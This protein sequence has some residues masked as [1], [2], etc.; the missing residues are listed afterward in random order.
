M[1][2]S[3]GSIFRASAILLVPLM[4]L[5]PGCRPVPAG[6]VVK[7]LIE[8][9]FETEKYHVAE[10]RVGDIKPLSLGEKTYM[11]TPG[12]LVNISSITLE[13]RQ[14][15]GAQAAYRKGQHVTFTNARVSIKE[16][17]G[18]TGKWVITRIE[19]IPVP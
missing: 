8:R 5:L 3:P 17:P 18:H 13:I 7:A 14:D 19:G 9:H 2:A 11:G 4:F 16:Q 15:I 1:N 6:Q 12:Y 10:I